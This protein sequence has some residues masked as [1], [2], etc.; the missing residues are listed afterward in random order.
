M[1]IAGLVVAMLACGLAFF[2]ASA[3]AATRARLGKGG[4]ELLVFAT[5]SL[6]IALSV[7]HVSGATAAWP[8]PDVWGPPAVLLVGWVLL[9]A[10]TRA[11][12]QP[13]RLRLGAAC[14]L[15]AVG[16]AHA[17]ARIWHPEA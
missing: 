13:G 2:L 5:G 15:V 17:L 4:P 10:L 14:A 11:A 6:A 9:R 1:S 3:G 7:L 16:V 12:E 8:T